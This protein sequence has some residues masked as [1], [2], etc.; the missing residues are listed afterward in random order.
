MA[1]SQ[2]IDSQ[3]N[4]SD[5][6][7]TVCQKL[8][9]L[10]DIFMQPNLIWNMI[11]F[12]SHLLEK[13]MD[14]QAQAIECLRSLNLLK[15]LSSQEH[16]HVNEAVIDML[17]SL[18]CLCPNSPVILQ[19]C[20]ELLDFQLTKSLNDSTTIL[21]WLF[22]MRAVSHENPNLGLLKQLFVKFSGCLTSVQGGDLAPQ[23]NCVANTMIKK[24]YVYIEFLRVA[25][26]AVLLNM[27]TTQDE[28]QQLI[29][30]ATFKFIS[31]LE[32]EKLAVI[33]NPSETKKTYQ[34]DSNEDSDEWCSQ[35]VSLFEKKTYL[36]QIAHTLFWQVQVSPEH[37][38]F[39]FG[40]QRQLVAHTALYVAEANIAKT[41]QSS[42]LLITQLLTYLNRMIVVKTSLFMSTLAE[43]L[44]AKNL[45]LADWVREW[46]KKMDFLVSQ[47]SIRV[48]CLALYCLLPHMPAE[49]VR[50]L[51]P[52]IGSLT[53][54]LL[55]QN[56]FLR[57][58]NNKSR[59]HSPSRMN[60]NPVGRSSSMRQ[61]QL[62]KISQRY[63]ELKRS[64][65]LLDI[66]LMEHFWTQ[67]RFLQQNLQ[68]TD[69]SVM[70]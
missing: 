32:A 58:T 9:P 37:A 11:N 7:M 8:V 25:E 38:D 29:Q 49:L 5:I 47:E 52:Q 63:E 14:Q 43:L 27:F 65:R 21:F 34:S 41:Q 16:T 15:I 36:I 51:L 54:N 17:K 70:A 60:V 31:D 62:E 13:N 59:F 10:L 50:A 68:I 19:M 12:L 3:L 2:L 56:L 55:E 28:M 30:F 23:H 48:N 4:Y 6:F 44:V 33:A 45:Q 35:D 53:F 26:E 67:I 61:R 22:T 57:L 40:C 66:D 64:D 69:V 42:A 20:C 46:I 24:D 1:L 18:L 39:I